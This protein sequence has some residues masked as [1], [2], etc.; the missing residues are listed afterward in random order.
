MAVFVAMLAYA[1]AAPGANLPRDWH[2]TLPVPQD[3]AKVSSTTDTV[4]G[5]NNSVDIVYQ[6]PNL[7]VATSKGVSR[8][9]LPGNDW[10]TF[11]TADGLGAN[12]IPSVAAFPDGVWAS[13]SHAAERSKQLI[14]YGNGIYRFNDL[15]QRWENRSPDSGQASGPFMLAYDLAEVR[16]R[17]YAA[18]FAG[19]LV[20]SDDGGDTWQNVFSDALAKA[21]F[22]DKTFQDLNNRYFAV[23]VDSTVRESIMVY[24]G[25]AYGLNQFVYLNDSLKLTGYDFADLDMDGSILWAATNHGLSRATTQGGTWRSFY[26]ETEG[27][28]SNN[29]TA[30]A[31]NGDTVWAGFATADGTAGAG[32]AYTTNNGGTWTVT[33]PQQTTGANHIPRAI[34]LSRGRVW[35]AAEAGGTIFSAT[36]GSGTWEVA[37]GIASYSLLLVPTDTAKT[38]YIGTDLGIYPYPVAGAP[39]PG[40]TTRVGA[41]QDGLGQ[42]V[43]ALGVQQVAC[44]LGTAG[45]T[46]IWALC[47]TSGSGTTAGF[48]YTL[49]E[50]QNWRVSTRRIRAYDVGFEGCRYWLAS[51]SG[52]A[53]GGIQNPDSLLFNASYASLGNNGIIGKVPH[54]LATQIDKDASQND[55]LSVLWVGTDSLVA[56]SATKGISWGVPRSNPDPNQF[57]LLGFYR[58]RNDDTTVTG[59]QQLSGNFIT[60]LGFQPGGRGTIWAATQ[61]TGQG[62]YSNTYITGGDKDGISVS[63]DAGKTWS[64]PITGHQVWNFAFDGGVIWAASSQGLLHSVNNGV[65]W[66]TLNNFVDPTSGAVID[67]AIEVFGVK[68]VGDQVWVGT[69][70]GTAILDRSGHTI[71]IKRTFKP[72]TSSSPGG[73]GGAYVTPVPFSPNLTAGGMRFH[74]VP[75]SS[76]AVTIKVYDYANNLVKTV[77]DKQTRTAGQQ[78]DEA[79]LWDGRNGDGKL[80][81]VGTYFFVI[82][83]GGGETQWGKLVVIP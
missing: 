48:A 39:L 78:Y 25:T 68:V 54:V 7:W 8:L 38:V 36:D 53:E 24:A 31:S 15:T 26:Q 18:C 22:T 43:L 5:S 47:D 2:V 59:F 42:K 30:V 13:T 60:A 1:S 71:A 45:T 11:D 67:S 65:T 62:R 83:F 14:R 40:A 3:L 19:G 17:L 49:D 64:V 74:Y 46:A 73:D 79:D 77:T 70:N 34:A 32:L 9:V 61:A 76:G 12:E 50:G 6:A 66:D 28:P 27:F 51:D 69:G 80:V 23:A 82:K 44:S 29:V 21:D 81:S 16:G 35:V 55:V 56:F 33:Q 10:T 63:R 75:P 20:E 58:Y 52:L 57:D 37:T 41:A 4:P 72:V